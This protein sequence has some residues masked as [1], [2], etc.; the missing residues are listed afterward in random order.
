MI[1]CFILN[2]CCCSRVDNP[3]WNTSFSDISA[4]CHNF[5]SIQ[6]TRLIRPT[7]KAEICCGSS[8]H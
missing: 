6:G 7:H 1:S 4:S 5:T 3:P 8:G 2:Q